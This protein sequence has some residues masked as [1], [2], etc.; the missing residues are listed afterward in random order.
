MNPI[1]LK[2]GAV[3]IIK[4]SAD[5][6]LKK[7]EDIPKYVINLQEGEVVDKANSFV[8][9][10]IT[11]DAEKLKKIYKWDVLLSP[12]ESHTKAGAKVGC[13]RVYTGFKKNIIEFA[14]ELNHSTMVEID[15]KLY[16][17]LCIGGR[18][19]EDSYF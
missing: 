4:Y 6:P 3:Y 5:D 14:Y 9:L 19:I 12:E 2:R 11:T 7:G 18:K 10:F 16:F 17:T 13:D 15:E 1:F 8:F